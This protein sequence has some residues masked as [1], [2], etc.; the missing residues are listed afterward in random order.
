MV[1]FPSH[2][3]AAPAP[4][5]VFWPIGYFLRVWIFPPFFTLD[6]G[7]SPW[8]CLLTRISSYSVF[9]ELFFGVF[10]YTPL[11]W[12]LGQVF[13]AGPFSCQGDGVSP[14]STCNCII[15]CIKA[16]FSIVGLL[17]QA[18]SPLITMLTASALLG[19]GKTNF[20]LCTP[21]YY[22]WPL[23]IPWDICVQ[24]APLVPLALRALGN[25]SFDVTHLAI[26]SL[27]PPRYPGML[28]T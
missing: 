7:Y 18:I 15:F 8:F 25:S 19:S 26:Y 21:S 14:F 10:W 28:Y 23:D 12:G 20:V 6:T 9:A 16:L 4:Q 13:F 2:T 1:S 22:N 5:V 11:P 17:L 3:S 24:T 27:T